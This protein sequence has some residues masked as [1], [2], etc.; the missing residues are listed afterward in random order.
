[1]ESP[2]DRTETHVVVDNNIQ[3]PSEVFSFSHRV[4]TM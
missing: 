3:V 4:L 1:M 2:T